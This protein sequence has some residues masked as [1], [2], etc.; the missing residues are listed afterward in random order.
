MQPRQ[1]YYIYLQ[2]PATKGNS[3]THAARHQAT[4]TQPLQC[5]LQTLNSNT[6]WNYAQ[7]RQKSQPQNWMDLDAKAKKKDFEALFKRIFLQR[8][9]TSA[10]IEKPADKSLPQPWCSHSITI[11]EVQP[12]KTIVSRM[13]QQAKQTW[14]SHYNPFCSIT[15]QTCTYLRTWQNQ[16]TTTMQPSQCDLQPQVQETHRTTHTG[17]TTRC[18]TQRRNQNDP[19]RT[20]RTHEVPFIAGRSHRKTPGFVLRLPPQNKA[21]AT[22]MLP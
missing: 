8:K 7:R 3:I 1:H 13:Q 22:F 21:H 10:K 17:T 4:L 20:R 16:M 5:D 11:Y 19:S 9:V 14:R 2:D 6:P 12:Q 15:S 18:R